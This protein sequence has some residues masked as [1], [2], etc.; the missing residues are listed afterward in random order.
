MAAA[1]L[2]GYS[3]GG[4]TAKIGPGDPKLALEGAAHI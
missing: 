1:S 4:S 3:L 2:L